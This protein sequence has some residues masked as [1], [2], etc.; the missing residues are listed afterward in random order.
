MSSREDYIQFL[1][2]MNLKEKDV[3]PLWPDGFQEEKNSLMVELLILLKQ[4][5][6]GADTASKVFDAM[7][8]NTN[9]LLQV[10]DKYLREKL[11]IAGTKNIPTAYVGVFPMKS[12][13][14]Q[15]VN[16]INGPLIILRTGLIELIE[17]ASNFLLAERSTQERVN[18]LSKLI[19]DYCDKDL[20]PTTKSIDHPSF[21]GEAQRLAI[22]LVSQSEFFV[23]CHEYG[24]LANGHFISASSARLKTKKGPI[25]FFENVR[26][27][28]Y[29]AD[30]WAIEAVVKLARQTNVSL[31]EVRCGILF[32][33]CLALLLEKY[34]QSLGADYDGHP[35]A[36][37]RISHAE[38]LLLVYGANDDVMW[39]LICTAHLSLFNL[40]HNNLFGTTLPWKE[41][42]LIP[43]RG[44]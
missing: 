41:M 17:A 3:L 4:D 35:S 10:M 8:N 30:F 20:I 31:S 12:F 37:E 33:F 25:D 42:S 23:L 14:G 26:R 21:H 19:I 9:D 36:I 5:E 2:E 38:K 15:A 16:R 11:K 1:Q 13:N 40:V 28:E 7:Q 18:L 6:A 44:V 34:L 27:K 24:H 43:P 29:E 32:F 22:N 39:N